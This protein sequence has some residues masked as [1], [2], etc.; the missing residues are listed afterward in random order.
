M[1]GF[2]FGFNARLGRL[3]YFL[4]SVGLA[5]VMTLVCFAIASYAL[6]HSPKGAPLSADLI[7][8]PVLIA[9]IVFLWVTFTLQSMRIRDIGWDPVCVIP[10]WFTIMIVDKVVAGKIPA[11]SVGTGHHQTV[12]GALVNLGLL[13]ALAFW[14]SGPASGSTPGFGETRPRRDEPPADRSGAPSVPAAR[15]ARVAGA[16]FGRRGG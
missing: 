9:I 4:S 2:L 3:H 12:V 7:T 1:L 8:W 14:P 10:M 11:W 16:E 6:Q 13:L 15:M 5:V